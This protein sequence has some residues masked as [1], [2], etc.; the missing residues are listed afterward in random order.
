MVPLPALPGPVASVLAV[1]LRAQR[2]DPCRTSHAMGVRG[3]E[4]GDPVKKILYA[5]LWAVVILAA[6]VLATLL[7]AVWIQSIIDRQGK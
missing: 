2:Q 1:H 6:S 4:E 3:P 7:D 5:T